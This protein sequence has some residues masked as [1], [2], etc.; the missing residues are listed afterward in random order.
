MI[1]R[2]IT[3]LRIISLWIN[4]LDRYPT[5]EIVHRAEPV[6]E[7]QLDRG[8]QVV[9]APELVIRPGPQVQGQ[10]RLVGPARPGAVLLLP[11]VTELRRPAL[12]GNPSAHVIEQ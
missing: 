10:L 7:A 11:A 1:D 4:P 3:G 2:R 9:P 8:L 12:H 6:G 5:Q